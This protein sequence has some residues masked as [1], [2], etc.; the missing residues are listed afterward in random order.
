MDSDDLDDVLERTREFLSD[1]NN[2]EAVTDFDDATIP[3]QVGYVCQR[4]NLEE[5]QCR[6]ISP[7]TGQQYYFALGS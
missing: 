1:I 6:P 2:R 7:D 5:R 4:V 3:C